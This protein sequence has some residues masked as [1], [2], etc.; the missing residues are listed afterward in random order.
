VR[1]ATG[2]LKLVGNVNNPVTLMTGT[3]S[4]VRAEA[5][6]AIDAGVDIVSPE[7]A[8]PPQTPIANLEEIVKTCVDNRKS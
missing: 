6:R 4:E 7:C 5:Q 3:P 1:E 8:V 2:K